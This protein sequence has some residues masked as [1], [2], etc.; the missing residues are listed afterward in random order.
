MAFLLVPCQNAHGVWIAFCNAPH[1]CER[2]ERNASY[3]DRMWNLTW[4]WDIAPA[5]TPERLHISLLLGIVQPFFSRQ[6]YRLV[7]A[8]E[9][10]P[11]LVS[12]GTR[13]SIEAALGDFWETDPCNGEIK[14]IP[15][16]SCKVQT[17]PSHKQWSKCSAEAWSHEF[18]WVNASVFSVSI[19]PQSNGKRK[20]RA[21]RQMFVKLTDSSQ[22]SPWC[23]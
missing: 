2:V 11:L 18:I 4:S 1:F 14:P 10:R 5:G 12:F 6:L 13:S 19:C 15:P 23:Q 8:C 21:P 7:L 3:K 9:K 16:F 22:N 20:S 17:E